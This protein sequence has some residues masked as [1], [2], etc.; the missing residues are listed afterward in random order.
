M[1]H[2]LRSVFSR[3]SSG[4]SG[5]EASERMTS[6]KAPDEKPNTTNERPETVS[7]ETTNEST[8]APKRRS[9]HSRLMRSTSLA[10]TMLLMCST[11]KASTALDL[12]QIP[13]DVE[14]ATKQGEF[15]LLPPPRYLALVNWIRRAQAL[16]AQCRAIVEGEKL[17]HQASMV[18]AF[19]TCAA[20]TQAVA[21]E[22]AAETSGLGV[23]YLTVALITII[24]GA[25]AF[26]LGAVT[27]VFSR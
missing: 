3:S 13:S 24:T 15:I 7:D 12:P 19:D 23:P 25:I 6:P 26:G 1:L 18:A 21:A 17:K 4:S 8:R 2:R 5:S 27:V 16:P 11:G 22:V 10:L 9:R 20:E 14:K